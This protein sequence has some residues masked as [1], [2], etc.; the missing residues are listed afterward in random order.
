[1]LKTTLKAV[2]LASDLTVKSL[3]TSIK[4]LNQISDPED[5]LTRTGAT[6]SKVTAG[7]LIVSGIGISLVSLKWG[8][9]LL[10]AGGVSLTSNIIYMNSISKTK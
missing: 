7:T 6:I 9:G 1:M 4:L 2:E 8:I 10:V 3:D 5:P